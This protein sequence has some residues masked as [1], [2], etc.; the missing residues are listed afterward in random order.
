MVLLFFQYLLK[1]WYFAAIANVVSNPFV[2]T[3]FR[4]KKSR[5]LILETMQQIVCFF[6]TIFTFTHD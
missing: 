2:A 3:Y 5:Q 6:L 4:V 1:L